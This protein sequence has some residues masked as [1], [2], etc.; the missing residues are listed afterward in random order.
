MLTDPKR[1]LAQ[2]FY[3]VKEVAVKQW[4]LFDVHKPQMT[5]FPFRSYRN[6]N[7]LVLNTVTSFPSYILG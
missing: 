6:E 7:G 3:F 1:L 5:Q 2:K 4:V